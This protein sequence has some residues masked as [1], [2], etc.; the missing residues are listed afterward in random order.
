M[1]KNT[2][3][4]PKKVG[5]KESPII[6]SKI[7][8]KLMNDEFINKIP[9]INLLFSI[10]FVFWIILTCLTYLIYKKKYNLIILFCPV[11]FVWL[12]SIAS[13]VFGEFRY[14]YSMFVTLPILIASVKTNEIKVW[15]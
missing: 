10:G 3:G 8:D 9:I 11:L 6:N 1:N 14:V 7:I 15:I 12:T 4:I 5:I 13:P 2:G